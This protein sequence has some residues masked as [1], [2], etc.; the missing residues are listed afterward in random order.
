M[1]DAIDLYLAAA[2]AVHPVFAWAVDFVLA[3]GPGIAL[4]ATAYGLLTAVDRLRDSRHKRQLSRS[5]QHIEAFANHPGAHA[6]LD[7][8]TRKETP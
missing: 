1:S 8:Q 3:C 7:N 2:D 5:S 4:C 6:S